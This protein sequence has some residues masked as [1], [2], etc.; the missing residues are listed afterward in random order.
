MASNIKFRRVGL[1]LKRGSQ[2]AKSLAVKIT[3]FLESK[4]ISVVMEGS[5]G[6]KGPS[7]TE[8]IIQ[9]S[10][11]LLV[12]GGDGT[13]LS[14]A[15]LIGEKK[16]PV[17][18]IHL[19]HLGFLTEVKQEET[20]DALDRILVKGKCEISERTLLDVRVRRAGKIV[21]RGR[22][23]NDAV[24]TKGAI[25]RVI[26]V[27]VDVNGHFAN[28]VRADGLIVSTPTGSTAYS[29]ASGG[30]IVE[31]TL[32]ALIL[33]PICAHSLTQRPLV[34][35]DKSKLVVRLTHRP[36]NVLLTLDGQNDFELALHDEVEVEK[37]EKLRLRLVRSPKRDYFGLLRE[38]LS[39]GTRGA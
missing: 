5:R 9:M 22:V 33:T 8:E 29:L 21:F 27:Q 13:L 32:E 28:Q 10:D 26:G 20:L 12:L 34:I 24:I 18:G 25:G 11:F 38:K 23:M 37:N 2:E 35:S 17:L 15:Q 39:F 16:I 19:G 4:G 6:A 7:G 14:A 36:G 3:Q 1:V 31:P 30:P